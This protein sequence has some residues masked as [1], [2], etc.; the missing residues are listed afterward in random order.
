MTATHV[1]CP[2]CAGLGAHDA[3]VHRAGSCEVRR[4]DCSTCRGAGK[5]TRLQ[6]G[7]IEAGRVHRDARV[8]RLESLRECATRLGIKAAELSA[9][10]R[11]AID[12]SPLPSPEPTP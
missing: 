6:V 9:M 10:E 2:H 4:L 12:P 11:G 8:D 3:L 7:W 5:I 1:T